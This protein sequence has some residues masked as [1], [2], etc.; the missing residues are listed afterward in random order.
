MPRP[1]TRDPWT[2]KDALVHIVYWK[3][4]SARVFRGEKRRRNRGLRQL[5]H[6]SEQ[7]PTLAETSSP[8]T[9]VADVIAP[10]N[11]VVQRG[12]AWPDFD[13]HSRHRGERQSRRAASMPRRLT[14][15]LL[16][17]LLLAQVL[18]GLLGWA[19]PVETAGPLYDLHRAL[20]IGVILLLGWKQAIA[21]NSLRRRVRRRRWDRSILWGSV[22]GVGAA[23]DAGP[24]AGLDVELDLV[25]PVLGL[26]AHERARD[27]GDRA[28]AVR[29]LAH[30]RASPPERD[31][32]ARAL[33]AVAVA[34]RRAQRGNAGGLASDRAPD[35]SGAPPHGFQTNGVTVGQRV[36]S[37][38]LAVRPGADRR[39]A[40]LAPGAGWH[41]YDSLES[42]RVDR[43]ASAA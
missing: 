17:A 39:C 11:E 8:G 20:G 34:R 2:L 13:G 9:A 25:R 15:D 3:A 14:N 31:Q 18:G 23:H 35:A 33:T 27:P 26:L 19:L 1:E 7:W 30:A 12:A 10:A 5:N 28:A 43:A 36:S 16:L 22:A 24:R 21:L 38:D 41:H 40:R 37:R 29:G 6:L 4:H 42:G 32:C